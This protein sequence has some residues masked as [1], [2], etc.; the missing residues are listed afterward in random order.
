VYLCPG[1]VVPLY[2]AIYFTA[3]YQTL[4]TLGAPKDSTRAILRIASPNITCAIWANSVQTLGVA[5]RNIQIG[6]SRFSS[7]RSKNRG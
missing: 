7:Q 2:N 1:T 4:T 5:L 6:E 3:P